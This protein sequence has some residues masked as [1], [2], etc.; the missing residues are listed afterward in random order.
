MARALE[1]LGTDSIGTPFPPP[2]F[3]APELLAA[4]RHL[5]LR[6]LAMPDVTRGCAR[7]GEAS[8]GNLFPPGLSPTCHPCE[9]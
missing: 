8:R 6:S 2:E 3:R 5:G 7:S 4:L 1:A 9:W